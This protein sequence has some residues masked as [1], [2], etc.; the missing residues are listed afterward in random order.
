MIK[1]HVLIRHMPE[2]IDEIG[3]N[4]FK[5]GLFLIGIAKLITRNSKSPFAI[6][7]I[8]DYLDS[9]CQIEFNLFI[10]VK[11]REHAKQDYEQYL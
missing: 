8:Y 9:I 11:E 3:R 5:N 10:F 7:Y 4:L 6:N 2:P 1:S